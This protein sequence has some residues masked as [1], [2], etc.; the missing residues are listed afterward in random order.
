MESTDKMPNLVFF[1]GNPDTHP[2]GVQ[3]LN[4]AL[5]TVTARASLTAG[6]AA[7]AASKMLFPE[8]FPFGDGFSLNFSNISIRLRWCLLCG[9]LPNQEV[10]NYRGMLGTKLAAG[11]QGLAGL[12]PL[13]FHYALAYH[14]NNEDLIPLNLLLIEEQIDSP[15]VAGLNY[16]SSR[17]VSFVEKICGEVVA[18]RFIK[19]ELICFLRRIS[20]EGSSI[21]AICGSF[22]TDNAFH[23]SRLKELSG[24]ITDLLNQALPPVAL[25]WPKFISSSVKE[26]TTSE[27]LLPSEAETHSTRNRSFGIPR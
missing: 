20:E 24:F 26:E 16:N 7:D 18:T 2:Q 15:R 22:I 5:A 3:L 14:T 1:G 21:Y 8:G 12:I 13:C 23:S 11:M 17:L 19:D 9:R 25:P 4:K 27:N 6:I 10:I